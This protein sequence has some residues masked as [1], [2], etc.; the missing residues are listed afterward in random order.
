MRKILLLMIILQG[1]LLSATVE[2]IDVKGV[3][4]PFIFEKDSTLPIASMELVFQNSGS[5][6]DQKKPGIAAFTASILNEGTKKLGSVGFAEKLEENAIHIGANR[7]NETFSIELSS[8]KEQFDIG[9]GYFSDLLSDPN[10]SK[11]SFEKIK[12]LKMATIDKKESDFDY[13][14]KL[15]LKKLS[16]KDTPIE[17]PAIGT[18]ESLGALQL[19]DIEGF[20][21]EHMVLK[22]AVVV[23]GGDLDLEEAKRKAQKVL[24]S[25]DVGE[26]AKLA[27]FRPLD[28]QK[29][30]EIIK[31]TQQAYIYFG[32]PFD[33]AADAN[34]TYKA[35]VAGFILGSGGFGSRLMEEVRVK[36]GLAY[37]A[38][39]R[40]NLN[41]SH[42]EFS[43]HLQTKLESQKDAIKLVK[44]VVAEFVKNGV[45]ED[46]LA[47]AKKF[48]I[49]SEPLRNETLSQRLNRTFLEYYKGLEIGHAAKEL[50][51]IEKLTLKDLNQFIAAHDEINKL[52][53]AIV[54]KK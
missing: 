11:E 29:S 22:R 9:I 45:S 2:S 38:Y 26:A 49:G 28:H 12:L 23:I 5:I 8:L 14:A 24:S 43:G 34:D 42:S 18:R 51:M 3:K 41:R 17:N 48:I 4:V 20:Y 33:L 10:F 53:F 21:K 16:Y 54:T 19:Q 47:Q 37:S 30:V 31:E 35:K 50:G 44:E 1:V 52:S 6:E 46:E 25:L 27:V 15:G 39:G 32:S 36:R 7:G 13:I 40:I